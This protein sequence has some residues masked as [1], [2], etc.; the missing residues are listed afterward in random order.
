MP[1]SIRPN[2]NSMPHNFGPKFVYGEFGRQ[3]RFFAAP[4]GN[5]FLESNKTKRK[6]EEKTLGLRSG[7]SV[8]VFRAAGGVLF[9]DQQKRNGNF[10]REFG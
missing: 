8:G 7:F 2:K 1:F 3:R 4:F 5:L 10:A 6:R 9:G